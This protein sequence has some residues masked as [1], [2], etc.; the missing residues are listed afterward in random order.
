MSAA[1]SASPSRG[2]TARTTR[3]AERNDAVE[4]CRPVRRLRSGASSCLLSAPCAEGARGPACCESWR[5]GRQERDS[6]QTGGRGGPHGS[7]RRAGAAATGPASRGGRISA[8]AA[9]AGRQDLDL[10][11]HDR[12][13]IRHVID[14]PH[15]A[16]SSWSTAAPNENVFVSI[17]GL[18][19]ANKATPNGAAILFAAPLG[20]GK[21]EGGTVQIY[22]FAQSCSALQA[23]LIKEGH[24]IATLRALP[25]VETKNG[26]RDVLIPTAGGGCVLV[27]VGM[28]Q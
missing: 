25:V 4:N 27:S 7:C 11:G 17:V 18:N 23:S 9:R 8:G 21:C 16:I 28:R 2:R 20:S 6:R 26:Y 14:A 13:R 24:T 1:A 15:T 5:C 22:P 12:R 3:G 19:Y 10:H